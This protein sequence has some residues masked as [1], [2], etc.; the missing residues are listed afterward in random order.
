MSR[1]YELE[2]KERIICLHLE[3]GQTLKSFKE[4]YGV[5]QGSISIREIIEFLTEMSDE[6]RGVLND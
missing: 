2:F 1:H 5:F 6:E 4:E 3:K